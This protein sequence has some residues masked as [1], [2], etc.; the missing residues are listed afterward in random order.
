MKDSACVAECFIC[1]SYLEEKTS[2]LFEELSKKTKDASIKTKF[3][4]I[5]SDSKKHATILKKIA[6]A[7]GNPQ[8][9]QKECRKNL[10]LIFK[11]IETISLDISEKEE[12]TPEDLYGFISTLESP[13]GEEQFMS[14]QAKT[15]QFMSKQISQ[16]YGVDL[17]KYKKLLGK[18][19]EDEETHRQTLE[20]IKKRLQKGHEPTENWT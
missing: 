9:E 1:L 15:F 7:I 18:I 10:S 14:T 4:R 5:S 12:I 17:D 2:Q 20:E 6:K 16:L 11:T 13:T 3:H 19:V 8:V